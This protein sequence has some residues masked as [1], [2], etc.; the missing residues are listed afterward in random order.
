MKRFHVIFKGDVQG[1]GFRY[2]VSELARKYDLT[3]SV[4]NLSDGTVE[5]YF[6]GDEEAVRAAI[7]DA[8]DPLRYIYVTDTVIREEE[9]NYYEHFFTTRY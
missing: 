9:V 7:R 2:T 3:G 8:T 5:V 1:V 4:E 6:Q